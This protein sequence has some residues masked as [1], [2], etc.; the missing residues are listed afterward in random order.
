M[1]LRRVLRYG[2]HSDPER[3]HV[4]EKAT[5]ERSPRT[6][7]GVHFSNLLAF[8]GYD[9]DE[10]K[11]SDNK[12]EDTL[13]AGSMDQVLAE[14]MRTTAGVQTFSWMPFLSALVIAEISLSESP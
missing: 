3:P 10:L 6:Y 14:M 1:T 13:Y 2:R 5:I 8:I 11:K 12:V 4:G 7:S 9:W